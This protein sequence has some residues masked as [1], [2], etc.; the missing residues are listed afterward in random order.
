MLD[1]PL[2]VNVVRYQNGNNY[3]FLDTD[4]G[5]FA[6]S[7]AVLD[8]IFEMIPDYTTKEIITQLSGRFAQQEIENYLA[9]LGQLYQEKELF[10]DRYT[11]KYLQRMSHVP[12]D[13]LPNL[14]LNLAHD[15]NLRCV[16]C[17]GH[18]GDFGGSKMM[19]GREIAQQ[20]IDYWFEL[21]NPEKEEEVT[22]TF[23]GG[24]PLLNKSVFK[25][26]IEYIA[27]RLQNT[28]KKVRYNITTNGTILDEEILNLL[29]QYKINPM[30]SIDGAE[31]I[32]NSNR[33]FA[34]A[35]GTY[36]KVR[37][38]VEKLAQY[39][40]L[41]ARI[42]LSKNGVHSF[43]DDVVHLWDMG[44]Q[45]VSSALAAI[46]DSAL[47]LNHEDI[48]ILLPQIAELRQLTYQ[49][50]ITGKHRFW[51]NIMEVGFAIQN[52]AINNHCEFY[53]CT[54]VKFT[55]DGSIYKCHRMLNDEKL[56]VGDANQGINWEKY[57]GCKLSLPE[58]CVNCE[59]KAYCSGG[60][61]AEN[62]E[63][64][65]D[66]AMPNSVNCAE[67]RFVFKEGLK[68]YTDL[69]LSSPENTARLFNRGV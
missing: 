50:I 1:T 59:A 41:K 34:S 13:G 66:F 22:V 68:L 42:T 21:L 63:Y 65:N 46:Q 51:T 67:K 3:F 55:P 16:Y 23:F 4:S 2:K 12:Q 31:Q 7:S 19:M 61:A 5:M 18:G 48:E 25:Y 17:F 27:A 49:N 62:Y 44:F 58:I 24:E 6:E 69:F 28:P 53:N 10:V 30:I 35:K 15:C 56:K 43:R 26:V 47:C 45:E 54:S 11:P 33:P 57:L 64:N 29:V 38:N 37:E 60:C 9:E 39:F 20:C 32:Q 36:Q 14:H 40:N 8:A 52:R